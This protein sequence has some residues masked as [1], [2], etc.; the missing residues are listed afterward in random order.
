[1]ANLADKLQLTRLLSD[2]FKVYSKPLKEELQFGNNELLRALYWRTWASPK[3]HLVQNIKGNTQ[4]LHNYSFIW[5]V[6]LILVWPPPLII[7]L[8]VKH[9]M[10]WEFELQNLATKYTALETLA[11]QLMDNYQGVFFAIVCTNPLS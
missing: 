1:L 5:A 8:D 10:L 4:D 3:G 2:S 6:P 7:G 9:N 11:E